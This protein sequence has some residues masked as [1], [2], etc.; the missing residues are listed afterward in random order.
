MSRSNSRR[1]Q[2][3]ASASGSLTRDPKDRFTKGH[4]EGTP[5]QVQHGTT[6]YNSTVPYLVPIFE[7]TFFRFLQVET[8]AE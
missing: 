2:V 6:W 4:D 7:G 3:I 5:K 1:H 8:P